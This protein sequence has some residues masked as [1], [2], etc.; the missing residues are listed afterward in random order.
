MHDYFV[1]VT[2]QPHAEIFLDKVFVPAG[3]S[4]DITCNVTGTPFPT[5]TWFRQGKP[6][7]S[8]LTT[9]FIRVQSVGMS[10]LY[11]QVS[12]LNINEKINTTCIV[13]V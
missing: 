9:S 7:P 12:K 11:I 4:I 13:N 5:A 2:Q 3:K 6:L 10:T 1:T 8:Q